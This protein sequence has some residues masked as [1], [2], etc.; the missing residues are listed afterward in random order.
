MVGCI[1][2]SLG[3]VS[4]IGPEV[5]LK[6]L[7]AEAHTDEPRYLIIGD[8]QIL[9]QVNLRLGVN[10][11]LTPYSGADVNGRFLVHNPLSD[12]LPADPLPGSPAPPKAAI[13]WLTDGAQRCLHHEL[14]ALVT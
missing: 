1:G 13:A 5:T 3:D 9:D 7:A 2:I 6:A 12:S 11:P 8:P 10:L 14:D 4:G